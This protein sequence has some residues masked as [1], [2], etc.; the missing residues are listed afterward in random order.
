M[1]TITIASKRIR[2]QGLGLAM[3]GIGVSAC[4]FL[5]CHEDLRVLRAQLGQLTNWLFVAAVIEVMRV[6]A[7][8]VSTRT[9]LG[10]HATRVP[11]VTLLRSQLLCCGL[12]TLMPAG[13]AVGEAAKAAALSAN[14]PTGIAAATGAAGQ[15]MTLLTTG[16]FGVL[17]AAL[18]LWLPHAHG[19]AL[20]C[21]AYGVAF[22]LIG[23]ALASALRSTRVAE[24]LARFK[25]TAGWSAPLLDAARYGQAVGLPALLPLLAGRSLQMLQ[26]ALF[27]VGLAHTRPWADAPILQAIYTLGAAAG[28]LMPA[29]LG[30]VDAAFALGQSLL[31]MSQ[32]SLVALGIALHVVQVSIGLLCCLS[33][34]VLS[35]PWLRQAALNSTARRQAWE[36]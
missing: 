29:Q 2:R 14:V 12:S 8:L 5:I 22:L 3:T 36:I 9:V 28:D 18:A 32:T 23:A 1:D 4:V 25:L 21:L 26:L 34:A 6:F 10:T 7:E 35:R 31:G 13:R 33:A 27:L 17:A 30:A 15:I 16:C 20:M 19:F 11:F 24:W